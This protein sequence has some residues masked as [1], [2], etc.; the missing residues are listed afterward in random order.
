M[1]ATTLSW[2]PSSFRPLVRVFFAFFLVQLKSDHP[3][4]KLQFVKQSSF[5]KQSV[6]ICRLVCS[7]QDLATIEEVSRTHHASKN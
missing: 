4:R 6:R 5:G 3:C 7:M 2:V 1:H